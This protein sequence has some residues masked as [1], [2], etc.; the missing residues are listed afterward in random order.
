MN[1]YNDVLFP[2]RIKFRQMDLAEEL[3]AIWWLFQFTF[4]LLW[5]FEFL[6]KG[7]CKWAGLKSIKSLSLCL[8][9]SEIWLHLHHP[10]RGNR[11]CC[12]FCSQKWQNPQQMKRTLF[13]LFTTYW[14]LCGCSWI[15]MLCLLHCLSKIAS[16]P[17]Q[18]YL[19]SVE[20][21][22]L[23]VSEQLKPESSQK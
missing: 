12:K 22:L 8:Q 6:G 14:D 20:H 19:Q 3:L 9:G 18:G 15:K 11:R 5:Y 1:N 2:T 4:T 21:L 16:V 10:S 13:A 17:K 23:Y 7:E